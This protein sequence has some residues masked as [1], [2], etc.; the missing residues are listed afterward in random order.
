MNTEGYLQI[1]RYERIYIATVVGAGKLDAANADDFGGELMGWV[2][3]NPAAH[4][5]INFHHVGYISSALLSQLLRARS[6][7][8]KHGGS[9]RVCALNN[10]LLQVFTVTQLDKLFHPIH[11]VSQAADAYNDWVEKG[12]RD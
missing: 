3:A 12:A 9:V 1:E 6:E 5:L 7:A 10:D 4:L 2:E 11:K 8:E